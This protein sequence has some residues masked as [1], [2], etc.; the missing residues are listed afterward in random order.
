M[1]ERSKELAGVLSLPPMPRTSEISASKAQDKMGEILAR[2]AGG[3]RVVILRYGRP[4]AVMVP[5]EEFLEMIGHGEPDLADLEREF[6]ERFAAMQTPTHRRG[7][8]ALFA[9]SGRRMGEAAHEAV[10]G[11]DIEKPGA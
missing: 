10:A 4:T 3:E 11:A 6:D 2:V 5:V 8:D 1:S 7:V 9:M